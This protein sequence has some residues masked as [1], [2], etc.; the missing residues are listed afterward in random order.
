MTISLRKR[1]Q[2]KHGKI[3]LYLE[4][5]KGR[6]ITAD[7]RTKY[8][9]EYEFLNLFLTD[10]PKT[11]SDKIRNKEILQLA[12]NLKNKREVELQSGLYGFQIISRNTNFYQYYLNLINKRK[13]TSIYGGLYVT[14]NTFKE[15]EYSRK[16]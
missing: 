16:H 15:Y 5:Y 6:S 14:L 1:K 3:S 4:I 11:E 8:I 10:N 2:T 13:D 12:K 9:R 7:G